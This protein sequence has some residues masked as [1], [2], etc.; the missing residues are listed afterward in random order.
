MKSG[1]NIICAFAVAFS[2]IVF[3]PHVFGAP[4]RAQFIRECLDSAAT[5]ETPKFD[6]YTKGSYHIN[7]LDLVEGLTKATESQPGRLRAVIIF[8]PTGPL[9]AY[10]VLVAL[11][12]GELVR[13]NWLGM[14]HARITDKGTRTFSEA[15][16]EQLLSKVTA[17]K[18][19]AEGNPSSIKASD[20]LS[21]HF[22][23]DM[24]VA[25]Y[26]NGRCSLRFAEIEKLMNEATPSAKGAEAEA[27]LNHLD[28]MLIG[29]KTTYPKREREKGASTNE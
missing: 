20:P 8:G 28:A 26:S 6:D 16:F 9:W 21:H 27:L 18:L 3:E 1:H 7:M 14:P 2:G 17:S 15:E 13:L 25:V 22:A 5:P 23:Y 10:H 12:E 11:S 19:L 29:I 4:D 24:L